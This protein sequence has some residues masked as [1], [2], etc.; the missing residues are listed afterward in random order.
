MQ[1]SASEAVTTEYVQEVTAQ[2][3]LLA[4]EPPKIYFYPI[5]FIFHSSFI[6]LPLQKW[7][8]AA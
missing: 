4:N 6:V 3:H 8:E 5:Y 1:T 7:F 2:T